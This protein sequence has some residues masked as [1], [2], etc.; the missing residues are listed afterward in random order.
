MA[1]ALYAVEPDIISIVVLDSLYSLGT[2]YIK[3]DPKP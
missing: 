1:L 2:A 3:I